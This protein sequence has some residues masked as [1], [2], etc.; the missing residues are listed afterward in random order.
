MT[1]TAVIV[2]DVQEMFFGGAKPAFRAGEVIDGI[3]RLTA[4]AREA[5]APVFIVQHE[6]AADGPL[7]RGS[8]AWQLP[9]ALN[10]EASD[11]S[12]FKAV[13]DSFQNTPLLEQL[14]ERQIESL[15]LCGYATEFCVNATARRAE[16]LGF[17]TIIASDLHTT[18]D[19]P[20][21]SAEKIVEH[22]NFVWTHSS[23]S[24]HGVKVLPLNDIIDK[25]FA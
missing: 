9:A 2:I 13:G 22:Q 4:A 23:M 17:E 18:A 16:L 7:A 14:R 19:K 8:A 20:H 1:K 6:S 15:V 3:N 10:R 11:A 12:I 24:G 21:L 25:E 5:G